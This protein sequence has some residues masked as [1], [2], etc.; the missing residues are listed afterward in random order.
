MS[1]WDLP[2]KGGHLDKADGIYLQNMS[3]ARKRLKIAI[4]IGIV[5]EIQNLLL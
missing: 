1:K 4:P 3:I 5:L 2:P